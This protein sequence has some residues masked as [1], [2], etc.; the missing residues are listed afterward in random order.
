MNDRYLFRAKAVDNGE[1]VEGH[2]ICL[3]KDAFITVNVKE[4]MEGYCSLGEIY[5]F[6]NYIKVDQSTICQCTG[7]K[8]IY[9]HDI[10]ECDEEIYE[11]VFDQDDLVWWADGYGHRYI[12][13]G[14]FKPDEIRVIGNIFDNPELLEEG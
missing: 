6:G 2:L 10:F 14:E 7:L 12:Q 4:I 13:L 8:G 3:N 5:G 9:E 1:W 11:I